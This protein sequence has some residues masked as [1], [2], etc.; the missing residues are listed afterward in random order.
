[1]TTHQDTTLE[2]YRQPYYKRLL[3]IP[4]L[5]VFVAVMLFFV[6][7]TVTNR[8]MAES[9]NLVRM[10]L[11]GSF[12]GL[13][14]FGMGFLMIAGEIDLSSG[15]TA[16]L[17][18]AIAGWLLMNFG[19]PEWASYGV[20]L[21]AAVVVGLLNAF[22]TLKIRMPSFFATL[23]TSFLVSGLAIWIL[24]GAW[25]Y[26]AVEIPVLAKALTPSPILTLPWLVLVLLIAYLAGDFLM[27]T[28]RLGSTLTAIGGNR[29]AAEIVGINVPLVKT[30]CFVFVS[31]C[32]GMAGILVMAYAGTTDAMIGE[33]WLLWVIA[34][35]I[36][37]GGS[38]RGGTGSIIG[39]M[40]GTI[41]I[42][43]IRMG[44]LAANVQTNAQG[45]VVGAILL[46]AAALD[47]VRRRSV[48]Y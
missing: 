31:V 47:V 40:L 45:I 22:I 30:I 8:S 25:L 27:R 33:G 6:I 41:L 18:A 24:K 35:V 46:A 42:Q 43:I 39:V 28:S 11:Q 4:E 38:L 29:R 13:A 36:I 19:W 12:L 32:C 10:A 1:M 44:L 48:Q 5:G 23:G 17:S 3:G 16:A 20:A 14:A 7:F 26:V 21:A 2:S 34:I 9:E 37:G 15:G